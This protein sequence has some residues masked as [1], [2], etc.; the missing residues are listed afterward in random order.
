M[1]NTKE[2]CSDSQ[3]CQKHARTSPGE[4]IYSHTD[5]GKTHSH[6][7]KGTDAKNKCLVCGQDAKPFIIHNYVPILDRNPIVEMEDFVQSSGEHGVVVFTLGSMVRNITEERANVIASALAQIPQKDTLGPNTQLYKWIPQN[8]LLGHPKTK[9]IITH[10]GTNAIYEAIYHGVPMVGFP[11]FY[12]QAINIVHMKA[13]GA[14]VRL[15]FITMT[16]TDLL[17]ALKTLIN[18]PP[19]E[20]NS[21][22]LST[23]HH[24]QS[25]KPLD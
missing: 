8:D 24:D 22:R 3:S 19:Y 2:T 16:S 10:S 12:D 5:C 13:K 25:V 15:D 4:K 11:L 20:D 9:A 1:E 17:N 18:D 6:C 23:I 14:A 21:M 7:N